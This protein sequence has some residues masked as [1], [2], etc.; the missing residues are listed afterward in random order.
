MKY[1]PIATGILFIFLL[2]SC[3]ESF[4]KTKDIVPVKGV[5]EPN[6]KESDSTKLFR[7]NPDEREK[8][9]FKRDLDSLK[10]KLALNQHSICFPFKKLDVD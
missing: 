1:F 8:S 7:K 5:P 10:P 3:R 9:K 4:V 2:V 6:I